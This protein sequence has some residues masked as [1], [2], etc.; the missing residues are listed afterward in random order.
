MHILIAALHRPSNPTGICRYAVNLAQCLAEIEEVNQVTLVV[1]NWQKH[2]FE[3]AF[4]LKSPKIILSIVDIKNSSLSRNLWFLFGLP[5]L[6]K[7]LNPDIIHLSFPIPFLRSRFLCPVVATIHDFYPYEYPE[8]FGY[9]QVLFNR[10]FLKQCIYQSDGLTCVS[11]TTL[12]S[13]KRFFPSIN[14]K[15]IT[16]IIYN[17]VNFDEIIPQP[18]GEIEDNLYSP[19]LLTIGQHRKNKNLDLLIQ[20]FALLLQENKLELSTKLVIVGSAGPET[21]NLSR[22]IARL[23]LEEQ[24]LMVS[25]INDSK[26]CWLYQNCQLFVIPSST[27]GFCIPLA[28]ALYLSCRVVCSAIPI[29]KEVGS[30]SCI[31]FDLQDNPVENLSQAISQALEQPSPN[32]IRDDRFSKSNAAYKYLKLYSKTCQSSCKPN[33]NDKSTDNYFKE[34]KSKIY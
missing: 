28:E 34:E 29:F 32:R 7:E 16:S 15:K 20:S 11:K 22:L 30:E 4:Y 25:A 27:E 10:L 17:Y 31:Y 1:G 26:L 14:S 19:F 9:R 6:A 5:K 3:T 12:A 23:S 21:D 18:L 24:V 33:C 2:Y 13:F 8:N